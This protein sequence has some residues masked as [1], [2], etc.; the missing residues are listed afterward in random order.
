MHAGTAVRESVDGNEGEAHERCGH[1]AE[2][3]VARHGHFLCA[4]L[5]HEPAAV[6]V[7]PINNSAQAIVP[8][9]RGDALL[10]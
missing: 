3:H 5:R 8:S 4:R 10:R 9:C 1:K 6:S 2:D 7:P